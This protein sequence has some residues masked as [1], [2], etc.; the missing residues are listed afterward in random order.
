MNKTLPHGFWKAHRAELSQMAQTQSAEEIAK[1]FG[2]TAKRVRQSAK[3]MGIAIKKSHIPQWIKHEAAMRPLALRM[4]CSEMARELKLPHGSMY[5]MLQKLGITPLAK[6]LNRKS[7]PSRHEELKRLAPTMNIDE[8]G[9]HFSRAPETIQSEL[10]KLGVSPKSRRQDPWPDREA[11]MRRLAAH[12]SGIEMAKR[13]GIS[14]NYMYKVLDRF[15]IKCYSNNRRPTS[16][17]HL[18][19]TPKKVSPVLRSTA[20][21]TPLPSRPVHIVMP[22][23]VKVTVLEFCPPA[24]ARVCNGT[25]RGTYR[26]TTAAIAVGAGTAYGRLLTASTQ[27]AR[28]H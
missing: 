13:F 7:L 2:S 5:S 18:M 12:M 21:P 3:A 14:Q 16:A 8:L 26:G 6:S 15:G 24:N 22:A 25:S 1:Y 23:H 9:K 4:T 28:S 11:E 19:H 17:P 27:H 10:Y 20:K